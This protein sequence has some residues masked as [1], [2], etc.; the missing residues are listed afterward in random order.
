MAHL[1][2]FT[3][4]TP[5]AQGTDQWSREKVRTKTYDKLSKPWFSWGPLC[6]MG[7]MLAES[8]KLLVLVLPLSKHE[9]TLYFDCPACSFFY[10]REDQEVGCS[11]EESNISLNFLY[12]GFRVKGNP[13]P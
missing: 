4:M 7:P 6:D 12:R 10:W 9:P 2:Q 11:C 5:Q 3:G 13:K 1:K 8:Q